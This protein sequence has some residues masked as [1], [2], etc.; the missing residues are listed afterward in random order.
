MR[1]L[2]PD[3]PIL[4]SLAGR[5][6][7]ASI[8]ERVGPLA[9]R[10]AQRL[11]AALVAQGDP[12]VTWALDG[13]ELRLPLSHELPRFRS[14]FPEYAQNLGRLAAA[15]AREHPGSGVLDVGANV[16]DSAAIVRARCDAPVLCVEGGDR[17]FEL[18]SRNAEVIGGVSVEHALVGAE[19]ATI[20]G[21]LVS[22]R[23]TAGIRAGTRPLRLER[24]E[25]ILERHPEFPSPR[26]VKTDTDGSDLAIVSGH[27]DLWARLRPVLFLEYDPAFAVEGVDPV[28]FFG[29][30][31]AIGYERLL[32]WENTG[33]YLG[34]LPLADRASVL[35]LHARY[36]G[37]NSERYADIALFHRDDL[38]LAEAARAGETAH[39]LELRGCRSL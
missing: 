25:T 19:P 24:I 39:A 14:I 6:A 23:G 3:G 1:W 37:W 32:V 11:R 4:R 7:R 26:L 20:S 5:V 33:E 29:R 31:A 22:A 2:D 16:G 30:L 12:F 13:I 38:G 28:G 15:V 9:R 21:E 8:D 18:L 27:L 10:L 34:S 35:D 17:F 36:E